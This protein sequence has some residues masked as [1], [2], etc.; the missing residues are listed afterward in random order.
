M[1][2]ALNL[3]KQVCKQRNAGGAVTTVWLIRMPSLGASADPGGLFNAPV[4]LVH[5]LRQRFLVD[6]YEVQSRRERSQ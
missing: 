2:I 1:V 4:H 5:S 3:G 6:V